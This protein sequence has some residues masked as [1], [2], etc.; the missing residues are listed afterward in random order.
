MGKHP[1]THQRKYM[2]TLKKMTHTRPHIQQVNTCSLVE[3]SMQPQV[4][5]LTLNH[6]TGISVRVHLQSKS[7]KKYPVEL[8]SSLFK[9]KKRQ[10]VTPQHCTADSEGHRKRLS[11]FVKI[12]IQCA[13]DSSVFS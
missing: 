13:A 10:L 8:Y 9:K 3:M 7:R 5:L 11:P 1:D 6:T 2:Y 12:F 4:K